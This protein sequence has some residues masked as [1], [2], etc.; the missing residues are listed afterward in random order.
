MA[1]AFVP[2][3]N[4]T[5]FTPD[6]H[7]P[8]SHGWGGRLHHRP[9]SVIAAWLL[10]WFAYPLTAGQYSHRVWTVWTPLW[11]LAGAIALYCCFRRR[12]PAVICDAL[13]LTLCHGGR[14]C[15]QWRWQALA[16]VSAPGS[17]IQLAICARDGTKRLY[18]HPRLGAADYADIARVA[19]DRLHHVAA[20]PA[21]AIPMRLWYRT[22]RTIR[23]ASFTLALLLAAAW[24]I[25]WL[26][27][28]GWRSHDA[29]QPLHPLLAVF[30]LAG[31]AILAWLLH[32][33]YGHYRYYLT[34]EPRI[35]AR[36]DARGLHLCR[37]DGRIDFIA[38]QDMRGIRAVLKCGRLDP[39]THLAIDDRYGDRHRF[40]AGYLA[41]DDMVREIAASA[42]AAIH[43]RA[44][45]PQTTGRVPAHSRSGNILLWLGLALPPL[46]G[47]L[48]RGI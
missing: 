16:D 3:K 19:R 4:A 15:A 12:R 24:F 26:F 37:P 1:Q 43:G 23:F 41:E 20:P 21:A 14:I 29:A 17:G 42:D 13:G 28:D 32:R 18:R 22:R 46:I 8:D 10:L 25:V 6:L 44:L 30:N 2:D 39:P 7:A 40:P 47:I 48:L 45:P 31:I 36:L 11:A 33:I 35:M 5:S 27:Y 34:Q 38:W 9:G